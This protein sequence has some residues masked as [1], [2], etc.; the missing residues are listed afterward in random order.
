MCC[1]VLGSLVTHAGIT[2]VSPSPNHNPIL[3]HHRVNFIFWLM[4]GIQPGGHC[5]TS[6]DEGAGLVV[7]GEGAVEGAGHSSV[8]VST[9]TAD[10]GIAS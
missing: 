10:A 8:Q 4:D 2:Q 7:A 1:T 6:Q 5:V 3:A 9:G